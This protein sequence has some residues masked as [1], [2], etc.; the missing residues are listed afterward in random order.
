MIEQLRRETRLIG[1]QIGSQLNIARSTVGTYLTKLG[2]G[3]L[4]ALEP[5]EPVRRYQRELAGE[6]L[7]L[8][9]K[10]LGCF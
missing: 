2:I 9:V 10:K 4:K 6:L 8:D 1:A 7:H 5:K 3:R